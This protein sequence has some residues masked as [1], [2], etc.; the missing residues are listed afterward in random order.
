MVCGGRDRFHRL[1]LAFSQGEVSVFLG[2]G[3]TPAED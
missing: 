3:Y 2:E 1:G